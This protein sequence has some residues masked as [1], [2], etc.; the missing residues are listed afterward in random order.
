M[1]RNEILKS[2]LD[3]FGVT[4]QIIKTAEECGELMQALSK[5]H[6]NEIRF[7]SDVITELADVSI[8]VEQ[9]AHFFG[10]DAYEREIERKLM[11]LKRRIEE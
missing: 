2:A 5:Y 1:D 10:H 11:R 3:H 8:M 6:F 4:S 7:N 9:L